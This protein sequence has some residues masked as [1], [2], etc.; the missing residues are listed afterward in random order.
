MMMALRHPNDFWGES[1]VVGCDRRV[2]SAPDGQANSR[3][4]RLVWELRAVTFGCT[5]KAASQ[6]LTPPALSK[7][8]SQS[9]TIDQIVIT[10][11]VAPLQI[12]QKAAALADQ[13]E[14][15]APRMIV[16]RVRPEMLSQLIDSPREQSNLD[17]R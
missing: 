3:V 7:L 13:L 17:L 5:M 1:F 12:V 9:E 2:P 11:D 6:L 15:A 14:Q 4:L 8:F 16:F 10:I